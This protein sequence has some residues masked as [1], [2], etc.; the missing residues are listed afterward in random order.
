[1]TNQAEEMRMED[2]TIEKVNSTVIPMKTEDVV[3]LNLEAA[4]A[5]FSPE[6]QQEILNLSQT[7]DVR[8]TDNVMHYGDAALKATFEQCG[9]FL[10]DERGSL[11]DQ[12]VI[13]QVVKLAKKAGESYEDFNLVLK[14]PG[15]L[16]RLFLKISAAGKNPQVQKI[17]EN[18]ASNYK[19]L[20]ELKESCE[21]WLDMLR[22][23][24]ASIT[25][26]AFSDVESA[27]LLEKYIIAGKLAAE[28]VE[29]E[30]QDVGE[31]YH[32][33]G[34]QKYI[35][36][37]EEIKEGYDIFSLKLANLEKSRVMYCLSLGQLAL[38][39]RSNRNVQLSINTQLAN[40]MALMGQQL[41]NAVLNAKNREV[42]EGQKVITRLNDEVIKEL[43]KAVGLTAAETEKLVYSG[44]YNVEAAKTAV[45]AVID[46]CQ[47]IQ[48]TAE[49]MLPKMRADVTQL[50]EL[51]RQLEPHV[52]TVKVV[53][54][55][56]TANVT[57]EAVDVPKLNF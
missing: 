4:L 39:R 57:S 50:D 46:S 22:N 18:A 7:I 15:F 53:T 26:S 48:K 40:S 54:E 8:K 10:K 13:E 43:S 55:K 49:E 41:R 28:R 16:Q 51:I 31:Q 37:Y 38:I 29:K 35:Q 52:D 42:L 44:F 23:A 6:E 32:Q 36:D 9:E 19:L 30:M 1:M 47:A 2:V 12:E 45:T 24:M 21:S 14:E 20:I 5:S 11:A 33:T 27:S 17:Q 3:P 34:M 56:T 25:D